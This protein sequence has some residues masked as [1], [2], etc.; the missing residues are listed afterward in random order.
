MT[1]PSFHDVEMLTAYLDGELAQAEAARLETRLHDDPTLRSVYEELRQSRS[2]LRRLPKRR[3]PRNF[4]LTPQMA[5]VRP[6][7]PRSYPIFRFASAI[8]AVL[9]LFTFATNLIVPAF[10]PQA[11]PPS[12][13]F[14]QAAG[15]GPE[16]PMMQVAPAATEAPAAIAASPM[17]ATP[18]GVMGAAILATP[19]V[20]S[21][22]AEA[23]AVTGAPAPNLVRPQSKLVPNAAA[24][25]AAPSR[26][27]SGVPIP[28]PVEAILLA[29]AV[30]AAGAALF[31]RWR[32]DREFRQRRL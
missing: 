15:S 22:P 9:F 31:V 25:N 23:L 19:T 11:T 7:L 28:I 13:A 26:E 17:T 3:A 8:A 32:V 16:N 29:L 14:D 30:L 5:G 1:Q 18:S 6:P 2:L 10:S 20:A 27:P 24:Q 12:F 4:T 21:A